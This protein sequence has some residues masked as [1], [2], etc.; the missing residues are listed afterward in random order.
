MEV[1]VQNW[2]IIIAMAAVIA[3][4]ALTIFYFLKMPRSEQ[5]K[6]VQEWLLIAIAEAEKALGGGTGQLKLR[7]VYERFLTV[8][9]AVAKFVKFEKFSELVDLALDKFK[10]LM[11]ENKK[12]EEYVTMNDVTPIMLIE[13]KAP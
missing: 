4:A 9:P 1:V 5:I 7:Y 6:K 12:V 11:E 3:F 13:K 8:F 10:V 2:Y